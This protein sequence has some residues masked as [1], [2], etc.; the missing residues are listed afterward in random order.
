MRNYVTR[1]IMP[2]LLLCFFLTGITVVYNDYSVSAL[3]PLAPMVYGVVLGILYNK[4]N[5][6]FDSIVVIIIMVLW[7]MRLVVVPCIFVISDYSTNMKTNAGTENLNFA[8]LLVIYEFFCVTLLL[9][10]SKSLNTVSR[11]SNLMKELL[12][13][14]SRTKKRVI[15]II[16]ALLFFALIAVMLNRSVVV[17]LSSI[18]DKFMAD[19]EA[20]IERSRAIFKAKNE[21]NIVYHLFTLCFYYLQIL[22]PAAVLAYVIGKKK[23]IEQKNKGYLICWFVALST[24]I[25]T[26]D[27][28]V[29][30]VCLL[31]ATLFVIY[32][33]YPDKMK[34]HLTFILACVIGFVAVYLLRK[35]G[36]GVEGNAGISVISSLLCAYFSSVPNI[37]AGLEVMYDDKIVTIFGDIVS[38]IPYMAAIFRGY[39]Q[40]VQ[41][42]NEVVYGF[43]GSTS[44]IMPLIVYGYHYLGLLAPAFTL[45]TYCLAIHFEQKFRSTP[46]IMNQFIYAVMLI[47]LAVGPALWG[48]P[49]ILKRLCLYIP[50]LVLIEINSRKVNHS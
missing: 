12:T 21:S 17:V 14:D 35:T 24:V 47:N 2:A 15:L 27:E 7:F 34:K 26:T 5:R 29:D 13:I 9:L 37:S 4:R 22:I 46:Q 36:V 3:L 45:V 1:L 50:L 31:L 16:C 19:G 30:T 20:T 33:S 48:F 43:V 32:C 10:L 39:P 40:S 41:L 6:I 11:N 23:T 49:S 8:V 28:N 25:I 42:Y 18:I 38:G 44:Q